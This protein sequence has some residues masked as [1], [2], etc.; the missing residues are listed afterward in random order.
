MVLQK[1]QAG[2]SLVAVLIIVGVFSVTGFFTARVGLVYF[3]HYQIQSILD[4]L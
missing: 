1:K 2:V 4:R 3:N